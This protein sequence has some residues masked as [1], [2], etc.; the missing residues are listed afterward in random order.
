MFWYKTFSFLIQKA[1]SVVHVSVIESSKEYILHLI[2]KLT[3]NKPANF[4]LQFRTS[5]VSCTYTEQW[6]VIIGNV[7]LLK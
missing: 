5:K 4:F 6:N 7:S 1:K 3:Y 2:F